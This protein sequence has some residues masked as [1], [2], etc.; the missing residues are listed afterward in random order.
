MQALD[1]AERRVNELNARF[2]NLQLPTV[3]VLGGE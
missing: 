1:I 2:V 3:S